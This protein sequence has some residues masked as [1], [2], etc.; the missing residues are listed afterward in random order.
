MNNV[1]N[2]DIN[3]RRLVSSLNKTNENNKY[4]KSIISRNKNSNSFTEIIH[5]DNLNEEKSKKCIIF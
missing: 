1:N 2:N 3:D 4:N 5:E